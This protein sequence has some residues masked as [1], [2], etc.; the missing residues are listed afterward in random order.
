MSSIVFDGIL[1]LKLSDEQISFIE[2]LE[3]PTEAIRL[4]QKYLHVTLIHQSFLKEYRPVLKAKCKSGEL[5]EAPSVRLENII[6]VRTDERLERK[7]WVIWVQ[8]QL[9]LRSYVERFMED[10]TGTRSLPEPDR[11]FHVSIA[12]LTGNRGDSVR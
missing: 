5:L 4:K 1:K 7:S 9:D 2:Q 6:E 12:N 8:N 10:L 3:L 11:V